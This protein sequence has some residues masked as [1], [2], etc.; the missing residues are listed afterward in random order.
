MEHRGL[1]LARAGTSFLCTAAKTLFLI[2]GVHQ[3]PSQVTVTGHTVWKV[4]EAKGALMTAR[5]S[6]CRLTLAMA[7]EHTALRTG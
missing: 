7:S 2:T 4:S 1:Y 3:C 6:K 5:S